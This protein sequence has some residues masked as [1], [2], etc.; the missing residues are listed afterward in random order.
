[1]NTKFWGGAGGVGVGGGVGYYN[2]ARS[3]TK[4]ILLMKF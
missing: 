3:I 4:L 1:M 2:F